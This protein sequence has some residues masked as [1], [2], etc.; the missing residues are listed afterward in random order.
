MPTKHPVGAWFGQAVFNN[1]KLN[2]STTFRL[3]K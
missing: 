1:L 2:N 3:K